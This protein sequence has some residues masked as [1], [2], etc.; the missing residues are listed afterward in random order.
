MNAAENAS[1]A[2]LTKKGNLAKLQIVTLFY[3]LYLLLIF[4]VTF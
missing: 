1:W 4:I 2:W 3:F